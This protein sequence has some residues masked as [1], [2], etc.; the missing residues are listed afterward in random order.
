MSKEK[1]RPGA[2]KG[3]FKAGDSVRL[4]TSSVEMTVDS[5]EEVDELAGILGRNREPRVICSWHS[6]RKL[7]RESFAESSLV[8]VKSLENKP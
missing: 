3:K 5:Y 8:L 1:F 7:E 2:S 6:G 4:P